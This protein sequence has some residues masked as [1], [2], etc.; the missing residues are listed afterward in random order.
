MGLDTPLQ[1]LE[2]TIVIGFWNVVSSVLSI[3]LVDRAGRRPLLITGYSL[4]AVGHAF[5]VF[6]HFVTNNKFFISLPGLIIFILGFEIGPGPIFSLLVSELFPSSIRGRAMSVITFLN[7]L[8]NVIL[9]FFY[10]P[11]VNLLNESAV[12]LAM[13]VLCI[14]AVILVA[15]TVPETKGRTLVTEGRV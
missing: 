1:M 7:W 15:S 4:M 14:L 5:V 13:L 12:F 11:L 9:V 3:F 2:S 6:S 8:S 10:L